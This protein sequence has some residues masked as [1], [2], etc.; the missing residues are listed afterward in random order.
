MEDVGG[1]GARTRQAILAAAIDRFGRDG[2]RA[3]A[4]ADVARD[5]GVGGSLVYAYFPSKEALFLAAAD[6]DAAGVI[7]TVLDDVLT[8]PLGRWREGVVAV[9]VAAVAGHPLARRLL[10]GLEPEVT[11]R[12]LGAP[13]LQELRKVCAA[14]LA[15]EQLAGVVRSDVDPAVMANGFVSITLSLLMSAVQFGTELAATFAPD[16]GAVL[17]AAFDPVEPRSERRPG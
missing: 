1:K 4:V 2:Y 10:G 13:A 7:H 3:T 8:K 16:I 15:E 14:R 5:A 11:A 6:E 17:S 9:A 12:V